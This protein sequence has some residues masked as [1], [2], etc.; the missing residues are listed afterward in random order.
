M[1]KAVIIDDEPKAIKNMLWELE[2]LSDEVEIVE[3]F[4]NPKEAISFLNKNPEVDVLFLDILFIFFIFCSSLSS[5]SSTNVFH[6]LHSGHL[7]N[8]LGLTYPQL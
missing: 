1:I 5:I 7:P 4:I 2:A 6:S 8:H 3:T